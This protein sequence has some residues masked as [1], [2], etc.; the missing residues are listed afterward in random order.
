[1][2]TLDFFTPMVD[3]P[4]IFGQIAAANALSDI[5]AMGGNP[6]LAAN[7]CCFPVSC[8][9]L[10]VVE[11]ILQG[12]LSK[13]NEAGAILSGGH[14]IDDQ[15]P[16]YGLSVIGIGMPEQVM[17][18]GGIAESDVLVLTKPLGTG[19]VLSAIK[20][21]VTSP[22]SE[23]LCINGMTDLNKGVSAAAVSLGIRACTDVTGFGLAGHL[24]EMLKS[25]KKSAELYMDAIPV[26][27][28]VFK[29]I[30]D[31]LMP[32]GLY[33]NM[34]YV[35]NNIEATSHVD[36]NA[37]KVIFDPQT[38]GGLLLSVPESLVLDFLQMLKN[39][40]LEGSIIGKITEDGIG[41]IKI[42]KDKREREIM[43]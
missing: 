18:N 8:L 13:V 37:L 32:A 21:K 34:D 10:E 23:Q 22:E 14:T 5:Y 30:S 40:N 7:I 9:P 4:Y 38:S 17:S 16:K 27:P 33:R 29:Y 6:L 11:Q 42:Y 36:N 1:M 26:Y 2:H 41:K 19:I 35:I 24:F 12:G 3:D 15:E 25:G 28:H 31:G 39:K 20:G 43:G